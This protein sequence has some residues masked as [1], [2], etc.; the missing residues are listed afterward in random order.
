MAVP[1]SSAR[2]DLA[3]PFN[4]HWNIAPSYRHR[5][6]DCGDILL[7]LTIFYK[8]RTELRESLT[9]ADPGQ[10]WLILPAQHHAAVYDGSIRKN[11][12]LCKHVVAEYIYFNAATTYRT[13]D[14]E[15]NTRSRKRPGM[16]RWLSDQP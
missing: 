9:L 3:Q 8:L 4:W 6:L 11:F 16:S 14:L 1:P 10:E 2:Y 7:D 15:F 12:V 5:A 13:L